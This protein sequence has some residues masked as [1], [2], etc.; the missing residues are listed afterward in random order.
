[1]I[2][3]SPSILSADFAN[4]ERDIKKAEAAG[5]PYLHVDVMDGHFVPN[6]TF[7]PSM[8]AAIRKITDMVL[9]VHLMIE[10]PEK[11]AEEFFKSGAD[12]LTIHAEVNPDF[13]YIY[14]LAQ[15]YKRK[16]AVAINPPTPAEA[17]KPYSDKLDM[18]LAMSVNPGF[19][20][21]AFIEETF[22]KISELR[23]MAPDID[24][25]VDGGVKLS[26]VKKVVEA[27]ANVVVAGSAI[28]A[29]N[30]ITSAAK[31]FIKECNS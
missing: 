11:Y 6:I 4:L 18:I 29:S 1:M 31:N 26:N 3:I 5:A 23:K 15:K 12:I 21:Q 13:D 14:N 25:E 8:V 24:I 10:T 16:V 17:I 20:A 7:G 2:K 19:G 28:F 27:G 9:D 22:D 30:D